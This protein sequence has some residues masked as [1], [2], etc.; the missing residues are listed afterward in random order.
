MKRTK[1]EFGKTQLE[2]P[3][4]TLDKHGIHPAENKVRAI[5]EA[6]APTKTSRLSWDFLIIMG[7]FAKH[8]V[9]T[10]V[11]TIQRECDLEV[12]EENSLIF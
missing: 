12:D 6:P 11:L 1:C 5:Q 8:S 10:T 2:Y 9:V 7:D 4:H 3:G